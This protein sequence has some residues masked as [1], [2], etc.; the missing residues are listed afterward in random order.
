MGTRTGFVT[1]EELDQ[2]PRDGQKYECVDGEMR[3]SPGGGLHSAVC[4]RITVALWTVVNERRLGYVVGSRTGYRWPG[5][6]VDR[7]DNVRER[8]VSTRRRN[9]QTRQIV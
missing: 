9:A 1:D 5:R 2:A 8:V 7:P 3:V 4:V 6:Y